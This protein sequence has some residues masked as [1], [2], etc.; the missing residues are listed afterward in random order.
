MTFDEIP[1]TNIVMKTKTYYVFADEYPVTEGH[2]LFVPKEPT[3]DCLADCYKA[4]YA[5]GHGWMND[6]FCDGFNLGQ[7]VT[8]AAGQTVKY[9]HVH[10]IPRRNGDCNNPK[11]GVRNVIPGKGEYHETV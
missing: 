8:E 7:N 2:V 11:G 6:E 10:L 5:W 4:A 1:W 9:P 3:W